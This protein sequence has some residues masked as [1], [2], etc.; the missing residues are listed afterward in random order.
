MAILCVENKDKFMFARFVEN[1][2]F[3][4]NHIDRF[5]HSHR[6]T[7]TPAIATACKRLAV[8]MLAAGKSV[9]DALADA[10]RLSTNLITASAQ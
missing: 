1:A 10:Y 4:R 5:A 3:V 6:L 2:V 7:F 8:E 9:P